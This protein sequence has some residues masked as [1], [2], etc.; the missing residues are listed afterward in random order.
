MDLIKNL[1]QTAMTKGE[2]IALIFEGKKWTYREL[3]TSIERFADGLV[4][5]GFQV[6][7][8]IALILGNSPHFVIFFWRIKGRACRCA[9]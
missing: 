1:Q 5:E 9:Y 4:S 3:M 8:H 7:D 2:D 6:G